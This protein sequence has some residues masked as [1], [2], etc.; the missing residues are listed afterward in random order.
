ML[1]A[2]SILYRIEWVETY[3]LAVFDGKLY[4]L[5]VSCIG[6]NGLKPEV[7]PQEAADRDAFSILYRIEWVETL[8]VARCL[9]VDEPFQYPVSD[10]MG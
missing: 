10:R 5:S 8:V 1:L 6:S 2:F 9:V 7:C 4:A 3:S